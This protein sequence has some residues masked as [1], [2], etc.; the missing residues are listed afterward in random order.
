MHKNS[1]NEFKSPAAGIIVLKQNTRAHG[2]FVIL[3]L[4]D[5]D[6]FDLPKGEVE[7]FE[8]E[9][10]AAARETEEES[11]IVDL[12]FRWGMITTRVG[13]V[14]LYIA[15]TD[16]E[17]IVRPNPV[18]GEYEH[19]SAHWLTL[20]AAAKSLRPYLRPAINWTCKVIGVSDVDIS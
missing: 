3:C 1:N 17:P 5:D 11:G 12:D 18:T 6:G 15:V 20:P 16:N 19:H 14:K 9:F 2:G 7:P 4:L 8:T 13:K 10:V